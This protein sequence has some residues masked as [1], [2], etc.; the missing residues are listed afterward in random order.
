MADERKELDW[1][2][3]VSVPDRGINRKLRVTSNE[4]VQAIIIKVSSK[5]GKRT[6]K[7]L[8]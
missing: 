3:G 5:L 8:V 6:A 4:S 2:L 1:D 7:H